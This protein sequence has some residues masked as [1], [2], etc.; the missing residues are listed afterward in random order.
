MNLRFTQNGKNEKKNAGIVMPLSKAQDIKASDFNNI[1]QIID[2]S[3]NEL[4]CTI[5]KFIEIFDTRGLE[6]FI[7]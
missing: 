7:L 1:V 2:E 4:N 6:G 3:G 5:D